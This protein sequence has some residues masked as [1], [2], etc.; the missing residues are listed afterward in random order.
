[1]KNKQKSVFMR[2]HVAIFNI[3][4]HALRIFEKIVSVQERLA[5][6]QDLKFGTRATLSVD[7]EA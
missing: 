6:M 2:L 7:V 4:G 3:T 1:M 5:W